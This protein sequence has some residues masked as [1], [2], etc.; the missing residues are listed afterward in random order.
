MKMEFWL[1][2]LFTKMNL[3]FLVPLKSYT[4]WCFLNSEDFANSF[5]GVALLQKCQALSNFQ[6]YTNGYT[7]VVW[8]IILLLS[9]KIVLYIHY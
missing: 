1:P 7:R 6:R 4:N 5:C 2:V 9:D 3:Y 8:G